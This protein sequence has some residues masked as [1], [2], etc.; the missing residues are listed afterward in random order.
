MSSHGDDTWEMDLGHIERLLE[1]ESLLIMLR[2]DDGLYLKFDHKITLDD[3][4]EWVHD[5]RKKQ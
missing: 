2:N 4:E 3:I 5:Q 1:G